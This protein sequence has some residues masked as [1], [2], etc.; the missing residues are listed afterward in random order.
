MAENMYR[1][2]EWGGGSNISLHFILLL[3]P[4]RYINIL[5]NR[6]IYIYSYTLHI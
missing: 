5:N 1:T 6:Q 3:Y 4:Y 2:R